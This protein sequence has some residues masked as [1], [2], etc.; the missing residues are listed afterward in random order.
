FFYN[1]QL[2]AAPCVSVRVPITA[3]V[4]CTDIDDPT[5]L[6]NIILMPNPA[7][8]FLN[9]Q[10]NHAGSTY[11]AEVIIR[12]VLG[13]TLIREALEV[14]SSNNW[15]FDVSAMPAGVYTLTLENRGNMLTRRFVKK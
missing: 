10:L 15:N 4:V 2:Q 14:K 11:N 7:T 12:N 8:S 3:N 5:V 13:E 9:V 1:W 6:G